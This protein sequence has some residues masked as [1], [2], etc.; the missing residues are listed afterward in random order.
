MGCGH[1]QQRLANY[2]TYFHFWSRQVCIFQPPCREP[3]PGS[4]Q[5]N[6]AA[7]MYV[8]CQDS[9][10]FLLCWLT[11]NKH[12]HFGNPYKEG[13]S[14]M[15]EGAWISKSLL[16]GEMPD[17]HERLFRL[18]IGSLREINYCAKLLRLGGLSVAAANVILT[19]AQSLINII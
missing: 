15:A 19:N 14:Q 18:L 4:G 13:Q 12:S 17:D 2:Q 1:L 6:V 10:P 11:A 8:T 5:W 16:G 3:S 9:W 7:T